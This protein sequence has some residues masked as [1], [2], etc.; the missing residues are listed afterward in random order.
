MCIGGALNPPRSNRFLMTSIHHE[1]WKWNNFIE[2]CKR[3]LCRIGIGIAMWIPTIHMSHHHHHHHQMGPSEWWNIEDWLSS[4]CNDYLKFNNKKRRKQKRKKNTAR[5]VAQDARRIM[6]LGYFE[7][8]TKCNERISNFPRGYF[9]V[10]KVTVVQYWK[11]LC[12]LLHHQTYGWEIKVQ[13]NGQKWNRAFSITRC[14][15]WILL[16]LFGFRFHIDRRPVEY[17]MGANN[18][19]CESENMI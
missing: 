10:E 7:K 6:I 19:I 2:S 17:E 1:N 14:I 8:P 11:P 4:Q 9:R 13:V 15:M 18:D 12:F 3:A 16:L 5:N